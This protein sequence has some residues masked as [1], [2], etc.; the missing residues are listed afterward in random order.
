MPRSDPDIYNGYQDRFGFGACSE[1]W[2]SIMP[3]LSAFCWWCSVYL[4]DIYG[5][6]DVNDNETDVD[7]IVL[8][9]ICFAP[10][11]IC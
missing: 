7:R 6:H 10:L 4:M 9:V 5:L 2:P 11:V 1:A 8:C 3:V